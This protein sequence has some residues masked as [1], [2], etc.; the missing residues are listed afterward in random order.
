[1][2][3]LDNMSEPN[4]FV[5]SMIEVLKMNVNACCQPGVR[6][7]PSEIQFNFLYS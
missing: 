5:V 6:T 1:M 7:D 3:Y 4:Q 2:E